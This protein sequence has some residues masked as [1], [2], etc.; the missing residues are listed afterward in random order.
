MPSR[1][2]IAKKMLY[3][4]AMLILLTYFCKSIKDQ[5]SFHHWNSIARVPFWLNRIVAWFNPPGYGPD[6]A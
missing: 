1:G 4:F 3:N 2:L 6:C 5:Q